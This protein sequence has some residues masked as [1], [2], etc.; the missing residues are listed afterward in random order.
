MFRLFF[1]LLCFEIILLLLFIQNSQNNATVPECERD[2]GCC[3]GY[4]WN[5]KTDNCTK[6]IAGR[7][8]PNCSIICPYPTFGDECQGSCN[9]SKDTCD[10]STGC[11]TMTTDV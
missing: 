9:C 8:G 2:Y 11:K 4:F 10:Y 3:Y 7:T 6:C 5:S 1:R